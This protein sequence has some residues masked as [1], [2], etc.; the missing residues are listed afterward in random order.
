MLVHSTSWFNTCL[1]SLF[2]RHVIGIDVDP[3]SLELA[4][5]NAEELEVLLLSLFLWWF[6]LYSSLCLN[7]LLKWIIY[8]LQ[9]IW[10]WVLSVCV[11]TSPYNGISSTKKAPA[12]LFLEVL[13]LMGSPIESFVPWCS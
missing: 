13:S 11:C 7:M 1:R 6:I 2:H 8:T 4:S 5:L 10:F 12:I 9:T 3:E